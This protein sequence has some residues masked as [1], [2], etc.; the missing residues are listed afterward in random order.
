MLLLGAGP[1][2]R[3]QAGGAAHIAALLGCILL[4]C[5]ILWLVLRLA[6]R[7][8]ARMGTSGLNIATRLFGLLLAAIAIETMAAGL[9]SLFPGLAA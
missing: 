5:S 4:V 7:V 2:R 1:L 8:G 6:P 3:A 9:K